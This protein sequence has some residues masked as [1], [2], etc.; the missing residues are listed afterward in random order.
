MEK[1]K[2]ITI[3][4]TAIFSGIVIISGCTEDITVIVKPSIPTITKTLVFSKDIVPLF[5]TNCALTGCHAA[6]AHD[7]TLTPD[8]AYS[9][10]TN[11]GLITV[12]DPANSK[13][14]LRLTGKI[15]PAMPLNAPASDPLF[16]NEYILAWIT[17]GAKNN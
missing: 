14:Y 12:S 13:L 3:V 8:K 16:I 1:R 5:T 17:Q 4:L 6:G 11:M 7:P 10:I 9:S 2:L 15:V